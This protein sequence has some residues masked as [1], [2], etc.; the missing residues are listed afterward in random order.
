[1]KKQSYEVK[2]SLSERAVLLKLVR[3]GKEKAK[4]ITHAETCQE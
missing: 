3:N 2:L 1:M 4:K